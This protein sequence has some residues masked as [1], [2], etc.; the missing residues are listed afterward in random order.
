MARDLGVLRQQ[1]EQRSAGLHDLSTN[2][3]DEIMR[4][5]ASEMRRE[6]HHDGFRD[7]QPVCQIEIGAH[8]RRINL[9]AGNEIAALRQRA[10]C[11]QEDLRQ[12]DPLDLPGTGRPLVI[13]DG[14]LQQ[15]GG[16]LAHQRGGGVDVKARDRIALL[17]H[18]ARRA[19]RL[20]ERLEHLGD[21]GLHQELHVHRQLAEGSGHEPE[22]TADLADAVTHRMPSDLR[23]AEGKLHHQGRLHLEAVGAERGERPGG[24][25]EFANQHPRAKLGEPGA[26]AL[27]GGEQRGRL[28]AEGDR[29]RLL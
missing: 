24:A 11:Q 22:E 2:I 27:H 3:V 16:V 28:E 10:G 7:D 20:V 25:G 15:R 26:V 14:G 6:P 13:G 5:L 4:P 9:E 21:F 17:R 8:A 12:R 19:A 18:G 1:I 29:H 23:L